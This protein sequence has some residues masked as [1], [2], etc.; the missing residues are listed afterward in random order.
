MVQP[1]DD[2]MAWLMALMP[3]VEAQAVH[4][5]VTAM[6]KVIKAHEGEVRTL[7]QIRADVLGDLLVDGRVDFHPDE[8]RGIRATVAVT[9]PVLTLLEDGSGHG[10]G[11][12]SA[13]STLG[14][15][16]A[17]EI[18]NVE[19]VGPVP[20]DVARRLCGGSAGF[21]RILTHAETGVV[22][23]V[24]RDLYR[25][26]PALRRLVRWRAERCMAP[27]CG[28]PAS[29]CELDHT[30]AWEDGG[31]TSLGNLN[32]LC[33]GHHTVKHHGGWSVSQLEGGGGAL[34]WV[35]PAGRRYVV[36]P[37]RRVPVFREAG[38]APF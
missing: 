6:A 10:V 29:R 26:P 11:P 20:L 9:V 32:P 19:G 1:A 13:S 12:G 38:R 4:G 23:S 5:R 35:S 7:D 18:P 16:H 22:L 34:E 15:A 30:V 8:A 36:M 14:A 3:A 17:D 33:T 24:G 21:M 2:G 37:E 28:I 31:H 27:G 25:P